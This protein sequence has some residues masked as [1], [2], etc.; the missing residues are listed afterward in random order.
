MPAAL[1]LSFLT[2]IGFGIIIYFLY[3]I[4]PY[5]NWIFWITAL[6]LFLPYYYFVKNRVKRNWPVVAVG[7]VILWIVWRFILGPFIYSLLVLS[8]F[9]HTFD[10]TILML[11]NRKTSFGLIGAVFFMSGYAIF[12]YCII[13]LIPLIILKVYTKIPKYMDNSNENSFNHHQHGHGHRK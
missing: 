6:I 8:S 13:F 7:L 12:Q 4:I 9:I 3:G 10:Y 11:N 2:H 5:F 1:Y